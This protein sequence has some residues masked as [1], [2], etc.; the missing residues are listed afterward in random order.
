M[1]AIAKTTYSESQTMTALGC[2][3]ACAGE[4]LH[5]ETETT[6]GQD[7]DVDRRAGVNKLPYVGARVLCDIIKGE[8]AFATK[9]KKYAG[10]Y[11]SDDDL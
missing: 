11:V 4:I 7:V 1:D 10:P 6:T 9:T 3:H 2:P 5:T 8:A